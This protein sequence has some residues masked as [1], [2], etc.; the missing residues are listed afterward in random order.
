MK[1][2]LASFNVIAFFAFGA[3]SQSV[4][5]DGDWQLSFWQQPRP[6]IDCPSKAKPEKT[7]SAKVPGNVEI[8]MLAAG[9][10]D[11]PLIG[12]NV[13]KLRKYEG[14]Q[15]L[16]SRTFLA[17][18]LEDEARAILNLKGVDTL[19]HIFINGKKVA[20]TAN[21][22]IA[23]KIDITD[24]LKDGENKIEILLKNG[25][26]LSLCNSESSAK[27]IYGYLQEG[28]VETIHSTEPNLEN[29]FVELTGR[30]F[31]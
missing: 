30:S 31:E 29:V 22:L 24:F 6:K 25:K 26:Q 8:D 2:L 13:Y 15:W 17:P 7:I 1:K 10:I 27:E 4:S 23:H 11:D 20:S 19:A 16:Y 21:M 14:Y 9:L 3:L 5:L 12:D 28:I 18:K